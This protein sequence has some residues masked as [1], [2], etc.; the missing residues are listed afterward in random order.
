MKAI[1]RNRYTDKQV[2][3]LVKK[4]DSGLLYIT[5]RQYCAA[6]EKLGFGP[7]E[8]STPLLVLWGQKQYG[9]IG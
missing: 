7:I 1:M 8:V 3:V 4:T 2:R 5:K 9:A 6:R